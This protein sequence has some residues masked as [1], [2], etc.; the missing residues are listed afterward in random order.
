VLGCRS[1]KRLHTDGIGVEAFLLRQENSRNCLPRRNARLQCPRRNFSGLRLPGRA[2]QSQY[3][4]DFP[5]RCNMFR[6]L[7]V[8]GMVT[9]LLFSV[10]AHGQDKKAK[11]PNSDKEFAALLKTLAAERELK[12]KVLDEFVEIFGKGIV[13]IRKEIAEKDSAKL[14][15]DHDKLVAIYN[16][17]LPVLSGRINKATKDYNDAVEKYNQWIDKKNKK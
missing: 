8:A 14:R 11:Q 17:E 1:C 6:G 5:T 9:L 4:C 10:L 12:I 3:S 15:V 16:K 2:T 7:T 13:E